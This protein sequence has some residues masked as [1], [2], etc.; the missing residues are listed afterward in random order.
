M[1]ILAFGYTQWPVAA[2]LLCSYRVVAVLSPIIIKII[3]K[4]IVRQY[5]CRYNAGAKA[6]G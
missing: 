1:H 4:P 5:E 6:A 2:M 3:T